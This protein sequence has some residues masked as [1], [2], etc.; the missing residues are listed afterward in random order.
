CAFLTYCA[1]ESALKA[2]SALHEQKT[3][4]GS[5]CCLISLFSLMMLHEASPGPYVGVEA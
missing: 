3:L 2:Q 1:R 4:P 5:R